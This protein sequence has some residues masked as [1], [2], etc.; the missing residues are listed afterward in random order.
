MNPSETTQS[1]GTFI[2]ER[3]QAL[4]LSDHE[5]A[6]AA[7]FS[8]PNVI[9]MFKSGAMQLPVNKVKVF[10]ELLQVP[11]VDLLR[12]VLCQQAPELWEVIQGLVPLGDLKESEINL[13]RH[14]RSLER[15]DSQSTGP[16]VIDGASLVAVVMTGGKRA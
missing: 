14:L 12:R 3:Q 2:T 16:L 8:R 9:D 1:L 6:Y 15:P 7:G 13:I 10:S 5:L 4:N 11:Q